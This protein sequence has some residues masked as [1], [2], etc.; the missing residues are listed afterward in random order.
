MHFP[1]CAIPLTSVQ[2]VGGSHPAKDCADTA[3]VRP[4]SAHHCHPDTYSFLCQF[5]YNVASLYV[6]APGLIGRV[7]GLPTGPV[8]P[9]T[10][11]DEGAW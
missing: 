5:F 11:K 9:L 6:G 2:L 4:S 3:L 1:A 8:I 10:Y 7:L